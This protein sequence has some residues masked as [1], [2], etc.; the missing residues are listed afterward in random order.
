MYLR[1]VEKGIFAI[2]FLEPIDYLYPE[3]FNINEREI[4]LVEFSISDKAKFKKY[5]DYA[6]K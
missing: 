5:I 2:G 1:N 6:A 4:H 3:K